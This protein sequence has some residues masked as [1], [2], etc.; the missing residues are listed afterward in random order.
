MPVFCLFPEPAEGLMPPLR[1]L[2]WCQIGRIAAPRWDVSVAMYRPFF[3][4]V[5]I[6]Y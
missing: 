2:H 5:S 1:W 6:G 3:V 4:E